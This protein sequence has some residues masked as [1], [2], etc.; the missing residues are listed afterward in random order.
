MHSARR[1]GRWP[2]VSGLLALAL[3][4]LATLLMAAAG[5]T[6]RMEWL[7]L[8]GAFD[9]LRYGAYAAFASAGLGL[10]TLVA[11]AFCRRV[12]AALVGGL[13]LIG[14]MALLIV[15]LTHLQQ[16]RSAPAIHD[17]TTDTEDPPSFRALVEAREAAP[18]AV[19]YPGEAFARLQHEAYP[20]IEPLELSMPLSDA[21]DAAVAE[22]KA[23]G[24]ELVAVDD[25]IIEAVATTTWFGFEDDVVIRLRESGAGVRVDIRSA[26]RIGRSDIG[27]NAA[28]IHGYLT[29]LESRAQRETGAVD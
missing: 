21:F 16:A 29:K 24:W 13:A 6:Y 20:H 26:S 8:S 25:G 10:I 9:L 2:S 1:G 7:S 22:V 28:R 23:A 19:E 12:K 15:P 4:G 27:A 18:N 14:T 17:I 3:L 11:A 5:P